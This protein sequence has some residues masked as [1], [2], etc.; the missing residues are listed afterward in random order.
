MIKTQWYFTF[1]DLNLP[2]INVMD[3]NRSVSFGIC[4]PSEDFFDT[5]IKFQVF[6]GKAFDIDM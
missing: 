4:R 2:V 5:D 6:V 3:S 1:K